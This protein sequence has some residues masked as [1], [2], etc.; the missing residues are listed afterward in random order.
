LKSGTPKTTDSDKKDTEIHPGQFG[1]I[2]ED[3]H[4]KYYQG[5]SREMGQTLSA[6]SKEWT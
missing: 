3:F 5:K 1:S 6:S 4:L 2:K